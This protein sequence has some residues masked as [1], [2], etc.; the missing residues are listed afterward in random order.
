MALVLRL[1]VATR[2]V[3]LADVAG[4]EVLD[5]DRAAAVVLEDFVRGTSRTTAVNVRCA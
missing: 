2:A 3:Q 1:A 5:G 4:H